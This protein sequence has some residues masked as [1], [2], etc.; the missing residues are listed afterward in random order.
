MQSR[1][2]A[3]NVSIAAEMN[4]SN[5]VDKTMDVNNTVEKTMDVTNAN[6]VEVTNT[7]ENKMDTDILEENQSL[8][9]ELQ[10]QKLN[11][12]QKEKELKDSYAEI[13]VAH[14]SP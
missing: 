4:L 1:E 2:T 3:T 11:C 5:T 10:V 6:T 12:L 13:Q 7:A 8:K 14:A 9:A